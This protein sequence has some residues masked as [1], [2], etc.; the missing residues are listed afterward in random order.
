MLAFR[1][2][3]WQA[4]ILYLD[5]NFWSHEVSK[6]YVNIMLFD[7]KIWNIAPWKIIIQIYLQS[8]N[9]WK[10]D[11]ESRSEDNLHYPISQCYIQNSQ[12]IKKCS[13]LYCY[14]LD[15]KN[16]LIRS[17]TP[18]NQKHWAMLHN[19]KRFHKSSK[20]VKRFRHVVQS[21]KWLKSGSQYRRQ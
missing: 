11:V 12:H 7:S 1:Q 19:Q 18:D 8:W 6:C 2:F 15:S 20:D 4:H 9:A 17:G 3:F 21:K 5:S 13:L 10:S 14:L 16:V